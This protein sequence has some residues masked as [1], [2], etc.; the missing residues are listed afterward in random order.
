VTDEASDR[1]ARALAAVLATAGVAHFIVP[2]F[3]RRIIP[4]PL[5]GHDDFLVAASGVAELAC[6][7]LLLSRRTRRLGGWASV[8]LLVGV[9]PANVQ[10]AL[11]DGG[12]F[13]LRLPLQV[14]LVVWAHRQT[15]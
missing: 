10:N 11:D 4:S 3:F 14:P 15:R 2:G 1:S 7:A 12:A 6:A 9:F 8:V 13:W 5:R